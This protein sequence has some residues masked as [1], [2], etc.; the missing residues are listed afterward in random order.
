MVLCGK[1]VTGKSSYRKGDEGMRR[2]ALLLMVMASSLLVA[3][4]VAWAATKTCPPA[5][6]KCK[7]TSGADV[8]KSTTKNNYMYGQGGNDTYTQFARGNSGKD[9]IVDSGGKDKLVLTNYKASELI[10]LG[11]DI[12]E[13]GKA[14][15]VHIVFD[16][17]AKNIVT[18][19]GALDD[20]KSLVKKPS[21]WRP[22]PGEI[23]V[24]LTK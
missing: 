10:I 2:I 8:L 20:N 9:V 16:K 21:T 19:L 6:K 4:G 13:N 3:S 12:N 22:G 24:I 14:D 11:A 17:K 18:L 1:Q 15:S 7:G 5:P 23:E